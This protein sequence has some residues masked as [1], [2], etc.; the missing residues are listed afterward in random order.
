MSPLVTTLEEEA[1]RRASAEE[2]FGINAARETPLSRLLSWSRL[3]LSAL[4][5]MA[6]VTVF[7]A[8]LLLSFGGKPST[9]TK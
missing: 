5:E 7:A 2:I 3:P 1:P 6:A 4:L 8:N 9:T